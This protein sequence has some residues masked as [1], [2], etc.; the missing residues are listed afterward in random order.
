M[1]SGLSNNNKIDAKQASPST[2]A[3][4]NPS[5]S[6]PFCAIGKDDYFMSVAILASKRS[7]DPNTQV[8][9]CLVSQDKR[10]ILGVGYNGAPNPIDDADFPW[11]K[12][13]NVEETNDNENKSEPVSKKQKTEKL[14][15]YLVIH[16]EANALSLSE[17]DKHIGAV[18]YVTHY[19]C[20]ECAKALLHHGI[21]EVRY[22]NDEKL[23]KKTLGYEMSQSILNIM[24]DKTNDSKIK[25]EKH[26]LLK[27]TVTDVN[28]KPLESEATPIANRTNATSSSK[29]PTCKPVNTY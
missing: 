25:V 11:F 15:N 14:K 6:M 9:A 20:N 12:E 2:L 21:R 8:G 18:M 7:K 5:D 29:T 19:P 23:Q 28:N 27:V 16:A 26:R 3:C 24:E 4:A 17:R 10:R 1:N 13:V 22:I